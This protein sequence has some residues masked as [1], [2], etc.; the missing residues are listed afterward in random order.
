MESCNASQICNWAQ[1]KRTV[2]TLRYSAQQARRQGQQ[3]S[4]RGLERHTSAAPCALG[5]VK[6]YPLFVACC[7]VYSCCCGY[8][9][10][11]R[12]LWFRLGGD[13]APPTAA[14]SARADGCCLLPLIAY[15]YVKA[16]K[17]LLKATKSKY[18][19]HFK[20]H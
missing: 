2:A 9:C 19:N 5:G 3:L 4:R 18:T 13:P 6:K 20:N 8:P 16:N 15:F 7:A 10:C 17:K 1:T 12:S 14:S 11:C